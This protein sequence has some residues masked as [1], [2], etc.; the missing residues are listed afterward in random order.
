MR[1]M[2]KTIKSADISAWA[3]SFLEAMDDVRPAHG[4]TLL[5]AD[6]S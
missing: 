4:K 5:P 2:R 3:R 1:A 6:R